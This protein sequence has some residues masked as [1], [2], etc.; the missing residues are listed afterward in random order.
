M[1][2]KTVI[3]NLSNGLGYSVKEVI[4]TCEKVTDRKAV[5]KYTDRRPGDPACLVASSQNIDEEFDWKVEYSLQDIIASAWKW[6][7]RK[8]K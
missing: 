8:A 7:S 2:K 1:S 5:I 3:Y 4:E 6:H